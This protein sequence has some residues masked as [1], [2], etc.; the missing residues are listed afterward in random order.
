VAGI[1]DDAAAHW[2]PAVREYHG[3]LGLLESK[4]LDDWYA[5]LRKILGAD[6]SHPLLAG[7]AA[8]L[9]LEGG[10]LAADEAARILSR[11]LSR[12]QEPARIAAWLEGFLSGNG[13]VLI[14][15]ATLLPLLEDWVAGLSEEAF[16]AT[17][18]LLRRTFATFSPPERTKVA[19]RIGRRL[20]GA[21]AGLPGE[22]MEL[23]EVRAAQVLPIV[24][25]L[26]GKET[27]S[28]AQAG[29]P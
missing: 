3:A 14:H 16:V 12:G 7:A 8:R 22:R 27:A 25:R 24:L 4:W 29:L 13:A 15:D 11:A 10:H 18:P 5:V 23:D 28:A 2:H 21:V 19:E 6:P 20:P 1:D 26:L 17:L 9:L